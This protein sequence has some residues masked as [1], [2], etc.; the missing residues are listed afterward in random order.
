MNK[1]QFEGQWL[2]LKGKIKEK[3][4][5][6]SDDEITQINGKFDQFI[7]KLQRAYGYSKEK[8]ED[9][10]RNWRFEREKTKMR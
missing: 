1:D 6:L 7:G 2:Q 4:G 10:V 8:A 3:W 5:K 9:E